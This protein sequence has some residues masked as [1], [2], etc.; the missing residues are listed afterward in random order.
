MDELQNENFSGDNKTD[1]GIPKI[2]MF[3]CYILVLVLTFVGIFLAIR[4]YGRMN[5]KTALAYALDDRYSRQSTPWTAITYYFNVQKIY[6]A[7]ITVTNFDDSNGDVTE[8]LPERLH[9]L[10]TISFPYRQ[11][12]RE[13]D[14]TT[15]TIMST[16]VGYIFIF[17]DEASANLFYELR[18]VSEADANYEHEV[19]RAYY[20]Y[21]P[22]LENAPNT[23]SDMELLTL[24]RE[25][26]GEAISKLWKFAHGIGPA[27]YNRLG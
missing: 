25:E 26:K 6:N 2:V 4:S 11:Y 12:S 15:S 1:K 19:I 18:K 23:T 9:R 27:I 16:A 5:M 3:L 8:L 24:N 22:I 14:G 21:L 17:D 7:Y 13:F 20:F 10:I